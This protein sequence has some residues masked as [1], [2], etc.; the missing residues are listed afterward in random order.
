MAL[1]RPLGAGPGLSRAVCARI[2]H[3]M[4]HLTPTAML[5]CSAVQP[6]EQDSGSCHLARDDGGL[7]RHCPQWR[8]AR[9][10][11]SQNGLS[12]CGRILDRRPLSAVDPHVGAMIFERLVCTFLKGRLRLLSRTDAVLGRDSSVRIVVLRAETAAAQGA[13]EELC[14]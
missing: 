9:A 6:L 5:R 12:P 13:Y 14:H 11:P 10:R 8:S 4:R 1:K 3:C 7:A 2:S